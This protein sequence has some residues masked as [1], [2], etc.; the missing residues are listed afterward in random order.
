MAALAISKNAF[1]LERS[2]ACGQVFGWL[3]REDWW[4]GE[5]SGKP[6][7]IRQRENGTLEFDGASE[8]QIRHYFSLDFDL[9]KAQK[10]LAKDATL[11]KALA[12]AKGL[13]IIRQEPFQCGTSFICATYANIPRIQKMLFSL[14]KRF[15]KRVS[16]FG[17][18]FYLFPKPSALASASAR[19]LGECGLGYRARYVKG[20]AEKFAKNEGEL[21]ALARKGYADAKN[22]LMLREGI[23]EKVADCVLLFSLGKGE[24][25]P[26]DVWIRRAMLHWYGGQI[27]GKR[28]S[29]REIADFAR[30][31]WGETAGL[32]QEYLYCYSRSCGLKERKTE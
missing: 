10:L 14:R 21:R 2:L 23:G 15:G 25:F 28:K 27:R 6:C 31:K 24:A 12:C 26:V 5:I 13:R 4:V 19:E 7:R 20:F 29:N 9:K 16:A 30:A 1:S 32:A 8:T 3:K 18:E 11:K 17:E 22:Q